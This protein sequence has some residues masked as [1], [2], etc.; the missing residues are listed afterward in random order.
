MTEVPKPAGTIAPR[1][2]NSPTVPAG[3]ENCGHRRV[4]S[5]ASSSSNPMSHAVSEET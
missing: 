5:S 3:R 2:W 4:T 1:S